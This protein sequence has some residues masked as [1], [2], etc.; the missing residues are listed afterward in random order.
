MAGLRAPPT[1]VTRM[2]LMDDQVT[3]NLLIRRNHLPHWQFGG[4]TYYITFCSLRGDLPEAALKQTV[5]NILFDHGKRMDVHFGVVMPDHAHVIVK[6]RENEKGKYYDLAKIL[7]GIKGTS[8]R[9]I[10]QLLNTTGPV[11]QAESFDRIIRSE[12]EYLEK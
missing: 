9:R 5:A 7:Q 2:T 6:P 4:S 11:W 3:E 8:S 1:T 10:N 12:K